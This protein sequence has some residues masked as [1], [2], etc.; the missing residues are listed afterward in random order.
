[1]E[2]LIFRYE[3]WENIIEN[4]TTSAVAY[5]PSMVK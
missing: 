2:F 5:E 4:E 1:M 3:Y